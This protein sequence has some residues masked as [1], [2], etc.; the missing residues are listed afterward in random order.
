MTTLHLSTEPRPGTGPDGAAPHGVDL[1]SVA[2]S[3][4]ATLAWYAVPDVVRPRWARVLVK[5]TVLVAGVGLALAVTREGAEARAA[6]R[7]V[8][9]LRDR[10]RAVADAPGGE[11]PGADDGHDQ[12]LDLDLD[13][14]L[15]PSGVPDDDPAEG[16][17]G[18]GRAV[19]AGVAVTAGLAL[20]GSLAV[21]G[22]RWAYRV[23]ERLRARGVRAPHTRVGL[24]LGA[25]AAGLAAVEGPFSA[26]RSR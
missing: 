5:T 3:A 26:E 19:V 13:L 9:D 18:P 4:G 16:T 25:A 1:G 22:E 8:R 11:G 10:L 15:D 2:L 12:D 24:V 20:A 23:G 14:D 7:E 6:V 17:T 21:L